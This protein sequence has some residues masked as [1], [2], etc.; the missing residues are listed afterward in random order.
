VKVVSK[1]PRRTL[2]FSFVDK[3]SFDAFV[4]RMSDRG[5]V[6]QD[7]VTTHEV[8]LSGGTKRDGTDWTAWVETGT[9]CEPAPLEP[10]PAKGRRKVA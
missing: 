3:G 5:M 7:T 10:K 4:K 1:N 8:E 2:V 6:G 9:V